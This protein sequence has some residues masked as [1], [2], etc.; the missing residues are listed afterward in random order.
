M[1]KPAVHLQHGLKLEPKMKV[2]IDMKAY[3]ES[4]HK[5]ECRKFD[6]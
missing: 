5:S 4:R 6:K 2:S 3:R 1:R